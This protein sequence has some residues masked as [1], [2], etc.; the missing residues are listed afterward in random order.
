LRLPFPPPVFQE[1]E[2]RLSTVLIVGDDSRSFGEMRSVAAALGLKTIEANAPRSAIALA[3]ETPVDVVLLATSMLDGEALEIIPDLV[4]SPGR[5]EV[6]ALAATGD[7]GQAE[8]AIRR[9]AWTYLCK[10]V[11]AEDLRFQIERVL[12]YRKTKT[13]AKDAASIIRDEIIGESTRIKIALERMAL[14]CRSDANVLITGETGTGKELFAWTIHRNSALADRNFVVIDCAAL[15]ETLVESTLFGHVKG[16]YTGADH[17]K[18]GLIKE[19]D[20][21]T[22]FLDEIGE[23]PYAA[24]KAFLRVLQERRFRPVGGGQETSSDFRLIAATNKDLDAQVVAG[25]FREDLLFRLRTFVLDLPPLRDYLSDL[26]ALTVHYVLSLAARMGQPPKTVSPA[27]LEE[28]L[29][30]KWP[31]NVRELILA[32][33]RSVLAAK[34]EP[35]LFPKHLPVAIRVRL[36]RESVASESDR[37]ADGTPAPRTRKETFAE[38]REAALATAEAAYLDDLMKQTGGD[39]VKACR[40]SGLSRSRL[41]ALLGKYGVPTGKRAG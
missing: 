1:G 39:T 18:V 6:I 3:A 22:L 7:P 40:V 21:G 27:F 38:A 41:Y 36:A 34:D 24:Q 28:L 26:P 35:I 37:P 17:R 8:S 33:E 14:A 13:E 4:Y 32:L 10:P 25:K 12:L 2:H 5:P 11:S 30:Y 31:G 15:P 16:A 29:S 19:A 23:L 9:G 20:G